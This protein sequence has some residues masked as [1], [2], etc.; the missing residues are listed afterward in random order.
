MPPALANDPGR[1]STVVV[2]G[3]MGAAL[4]YLAFRLAGPLYGLGIAVILA[5][6]AWTLI[7]SDPHDT[8]S[9]S[10]WRLSVRPLVPWL[11]GVASGWAVQAGFLKDP[12]L[13]GAW[14]FLNAHFF[15]QA[16]RG[17]ARADAREEAK[18]VTVA[19][20][21]GVVPPLTGGEQ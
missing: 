13:V 15:F 11:F 16:Q 19:A 21:T 3:L 6:E 14:F 8:L 9:E 12:W 5:Y 17:A 18:R 2:G 7:N 4:L 20:E 10:V 1:H